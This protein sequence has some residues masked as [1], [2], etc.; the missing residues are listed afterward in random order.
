MEQT[1][2]RR[3]DDHE[4]LISPDFERHLIAGHLSPILQRVLHDDTLSLEIRDGYVDI[5]YRGG[6]LLGIHGNGRS[7]KF[8]TEF[9]WRYCNVDPNY[10]PFLPKRPPHVITSKEQAT[11]WV[12]AFALY[13]QVMDVRFFE[14]PK[15][16]REFQQLVLRDNNRHV[17]GELSEYTIIDIE[18]VQPAG[19]FSGK[20]ADFRF[21][22][23]GLR[24][25]AK[26]PSRRSHVATPVLVE[27]KVGD[28]A[29]ASHPVGRDS[30][31]LE[32]GLKKHVGDIEEFL[33]PAPGA[34]TS[35]RYDRLRTELSAVLATKQRL[36]LPSI[37]QNMKELEI[38]ELSD[39][40]EVVFILA[41]HQPRSGI[42][43]DEL[44][45]LHPGTNA[46]Y[47]VAAVSYGGY[48][49]FAH[50]MIPLEEFTAELLRSCPAP[51]RPR[52][53]HVALL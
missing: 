41:N 34:T 40:P 28:G 6:R 24:W 39:R 25:P 32:P 46:D 4:R 19:A 13:K 36:K 12:D 10:C 16:E 44:E 50:N 47:L 5:Y 38:T 52:I 20:R 49:L 14:H 31:R 29:L 42:L 21:D 35:K 37:P 51:R 2:V 9:D 23:I 53:E 33:K 45:T 3:G 27:M 8:R 15:L 11:E 30:A 7:G 18:Y 22:M 26:G 48:A 17:V 43:R 1:E